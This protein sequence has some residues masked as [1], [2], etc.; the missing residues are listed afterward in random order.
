VRVT[1][2]DCVGDDSRKLP[3]VTFGETMSLFGASG[4]D[5]GLVLESE[6]PRQRD[7]FT[8]FPP[9]NTHL[10]MYVPFP[11]LAVTSLAPPS[12]PESGLENAFC[13]FQPRLIWA[14]ISVQFSMA[15]S[16]CSVFF[17]RPAW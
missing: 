6:I 14:S 12:G 15:S 17:Y 16:T 1:D 8:L 3:L 10:T 4:N 9:A 13:L 7:L 11:H 5:M 2:K